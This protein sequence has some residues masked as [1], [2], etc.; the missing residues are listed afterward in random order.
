MKIGLIVNTAWNVFN[1]RQGL[2]QALIY[3]GHEVIVIAPMDTFASKL[4]TLGVKF[5]PLDMDNHGINPFRDFILLQGYWRL[6]RRE[7][8]NLILAYTIKPNIYASLAARCLKIPIVNNI[9]GLGT[10]F[11]KNTFV[12]FVVKTLYKIAMA[13]SLHVFFQNQEDCFL[14]QQ[15]NLVSLEKTSVLPGSGIN[16]E[17]FSPVVTSND[18]SASSLRFLMISRL[19]IEKG[20]NE[21]AEAARLIKERYPNVVFQLLGPV[22]LHNP[23]R[24]KHS[25]LNKW[26]QNDILQYLGRAQDV[27]P[28][29]EAA[30]CIVLPS[31]REG[32]PRVLLEAGAMERPVIASNVPG[33]RD[34]VVDEITGF[35]CEAGSGRALARCMEKFLKL[36]PDEH[37]SMGRAGRKRVQTKFD[38]KIVINSYLDVVRMA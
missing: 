38:E 37:L 20:V 9:S 27:R 4:E 36:S 7:K 21:F 17:S 30:H 32:L 18:F 19:V 15:L 2:I 29:I 28:Y 5:L 6:M 35:L 33:C 3:E 31:Y 34:V 12:T 16:I 25:L 8:L 11:I 13:K 1:F 22:E 10:V 24:I 26:T 14:F 23:S